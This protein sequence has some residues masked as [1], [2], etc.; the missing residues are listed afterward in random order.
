[1]RSLAGLL[2]VVPLAAVT[3]AR[4]LN[5]E[6]PEIKQDVDNMLNEFDKWVHYKAPD[7]D[8]PDNPKKAPE[9]AAGATYWMEQIMHQGLAPFNSNPGAYQVFRNVK[10]FGAKGVHRKAVPVAQVDRTLILFR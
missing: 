4:H 6:P 3:L 7:H 5:Y 9:P 8:V 10:D 1:M 2:A